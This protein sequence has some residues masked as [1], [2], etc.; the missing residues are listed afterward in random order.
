MN[1]VPKAIGIE[2][3]GDNAQDLN[4]KLKLLI[5]RVSQLLGTKQNY[6]CFGA[7]SHA[8]HPHLPTQS[9]L[10]LSAKSE[11]M[12]KILNRENTIFQKIRNQTTQLKMGKRPEQRPLQKRYTDWQ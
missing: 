4:S 3:V 11:T 2:L 6:V 5:S 9:F 12:S 10:I 1:D 8:N 7:L